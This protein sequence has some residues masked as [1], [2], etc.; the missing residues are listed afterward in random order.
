[1]TARARTGYAVTKLAQEQLCRVWARETGAALA[2]LRYHNVYG[3]R[4]PRDTP[5][6]GVAAIFASALRRGRPPQVFEDGGQRR[7][8]ICVQD[9]ARA[10]AVALDSL[11]GRCS[12]NGQNP[13]RVYNVASG[14]QRTVLDLATALSRAV[15][16]PAPA[17][18]GEFRLGDVRHVTASSERIRRELGWRPTVDF[19]AG[20]AGLA[21]ALTRAGP[22]GPTAEVC[23][24]EGA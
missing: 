13:V 9:V 16:G 5:Y 2:I 3:A 19:G 8:F 23:D 18:T 10:N 24:R 22:E 6:A 20:M 17:V 21:G 12:G 4:M 11:S 7:D 14:D 15:A 1:V